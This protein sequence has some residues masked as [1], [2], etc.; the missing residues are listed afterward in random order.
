MNESNR[1]QI[2]DNQLS[3]DLDQKEDSIPKITPTA[4]PIFKSD[5]S[6]NKNK[7]KNNKTSEKSETDSKPRNKLIKSEP[8]SLQKYP[9]PKRV[10][11]KIGEVEIINDKHEMDEDDDECEDDDLLKHLAKR[12][13][14]RFLA[15]KHISNFEQALAT[16]DNPN[17]LSQTKLVLAHE[18]IKFL[19]ANQL[20]ADGT[21]LSLLRRIWP[22]MDDNEFDQMVAVSFKKA[23]KWLIKK[24]FIKPNGKSI[25][26]F[27]MRFKIILCSRL[28]SIN[29]FS[30]IEETEIKSSTINTLSTSNPY[31]IP[32]T[33]YYL[34]INHPYYNIR[35]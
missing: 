28:M 20:K 5:Q 3:I 26:P 30:T 2:D 23:R 25:K 1:I 32:I 6:Q 7:N 29:S 31:S 13:E 27:Q 11:I 24:A 17:N 22:S 8:T 4:T 14:F 19:V 16:I 15:D 18:L 12:D 33:I 21:A 10:K 35:K 34:Y 9:A